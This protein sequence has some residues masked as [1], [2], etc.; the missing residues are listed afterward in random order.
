MTQMVYTKDLKPLLDDR[1][2]KNEA[3]IIP[4]GSSSSSPNSLNNYMGLGFYYQSNPENITELPESGKGFFLLVEDFGTKNY[5]KQTLTHIE[6]NKTYTRIRNNGLWGSWREIS[7]DTLY[8]ADNDSLKL[9]FN[10]FSV[11]ENGIKTSHIK[12][13][14]INFKKV[15]EYISTGE[16]SSAGYLKIMRIQWDLTKKVPITFDIYRANKG[17]SHITLIF[18][19]FPNKI[20]CTGEKIEVYAIKDRETGQGVWDIVVKKEQ[21]ESIIVKNIQLPYTYSEN[22]TISQLDIFL[23]DFNPDTQSWE[24]ANQVGK[25]TGFG[26]EEKTKLDNSITKTS[27]DQGFL[28]TDGSKDSTGKLYTTTD[29][30]E[31]TN[32][33]AAKPDLGNTENTAARGN[34]THNYE[35]TVTSNSTNAVQSKAVY[36]YINNIIGNIDNWLVK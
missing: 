32:A 11:K 36:N 9:E 29:K 13:G 18:H 35:A 16:T 15:E 22:I 33:I 34:H 4:N 8:T 31:L 26:E 25:Y 1:Y 23:P 5:T 24:N 3:T 7:A 28:K 21:N 6:S 17:V 30:T 19:A 2:I 27:T 20:T 14:A 10:Q 12:D